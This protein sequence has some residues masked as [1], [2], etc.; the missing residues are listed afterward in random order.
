MNQPT[1]L[2]ETAYYYPEPFW[3]P[4]EGSWIKT[5]LLFF[6]EVAIL[7]PDYMRGR[8]AMVDPSL[9]EPL[10]DMRLLRILEPEWFVD[11][12]LTIQ[13]T[14]VVYSLVVE[15][16]FDSASD[17]EGLA[18]LSMSRM[19]YAAVHSLAHRV[20]KELARRGL[21]TESEDGLSIPMRPQVRNT[22][23]VLIAQLA[24]EAGKRHGLD[25]H[26][27]TNNTSVQTYFETLLSREPMPSRGHVVAFDLDLVSVDLDLV[28]LD[29][30]LAFRQEH[31]EAHR[32]YMQNLRT[33][34]LQLGLLDEADRARELADRRAELEE[35][36]RDL[37]GRARRVWKSPVDV[38]GFGLGIAG[39]AWSLAMHNPVPAALAALGVGLRML[40]KKPAGNVYSYLFAAGR[41]FPQRA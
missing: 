19:G 17:E 39:A 16:A 25:L 27:V 24:R 40:P 33:F 37:R 5:L 15:G 4:T 32:R 20:Y 14:D 34:S 13:L 6:D 22:Y 11:E 3:R 28:P 8:P 38:T 12:Q 30:V 18:A 21:A 31:G 2:P 1:S 7:L 10:Q 9:V 26:P 36:A 29:D 23:L 41:T 35:A